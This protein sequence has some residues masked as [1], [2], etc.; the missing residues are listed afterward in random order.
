MRLQRQVRGQPRLTHTRLPADQRQAQRPLTRLSPQLC[1]PLA[2]GQPPDIAG[3]RQLTQPLRQRDPDDGGRLPLELERLHRL[4]DALQLEIAE[5]LEAVTSRAPASWRT[6][7]VDDDLPALQRGRTAAPPRPPARRNSRRPRPWRRRRSRRSA[8]RAAPLRGG[9]A[10]RQPAASGPRTPTTGRRCENT[11]IS[12]SPRFL[13]SRPPVRS[14]APRSSP[15]CSARKLLRG[16][17]ANA[18]GH[19]GRTHQIGHQDRDRLC[20]SRAHPPIIRL[21]G[22]W[23]ND[24]TPCCSYSRLSRPVFDE[25]RQASTHLVDELHDQ[26][27]GIQVRRPRRYA[28]IRVSSTGGGGR[29]CAGSSSA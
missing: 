12:P 20:G 29:S 1:Q 11:T 24:V 14:S 28:P 26:P 23:C 6:R 13:T 21:S 17:G 5:R 25:D 18:V 16:L 4:G 8:P 27:S 19:R 10:P 2:L 3:R 15:K 9:C 22:D 7:V